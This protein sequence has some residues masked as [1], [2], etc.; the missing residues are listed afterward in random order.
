MSDD[1]LPCPFCG[2]KAEFVKRDV[3]PQGDTWYGK[4]VEEFV[5]C[6]G[7]SAC[8]FDGYFHEGFYEKAKA[9][10]AWNRRS[11]TE[12]VPDAQKTL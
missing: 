6:Q 1:F 8:L 4:K 9:V 11:V 3:E 10:E 12:V 7:C 2:G 5:E